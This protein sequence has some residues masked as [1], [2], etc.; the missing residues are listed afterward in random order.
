[1]KCLLRRLLDRLDHEVEQA[2]AA[3][4]MTQIAHAQATQT[5]AIN[6]TMR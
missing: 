5:A 3:A 1:M 2:T 4:I 6:A